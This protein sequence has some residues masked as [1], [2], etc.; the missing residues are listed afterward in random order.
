MVTKSAR[1]RHPKSIEGRP[2]DPQIW[3][4][5]PILL[6]CLSLLTSPAFAQSSS[7]SSSQSGPTALYNIATIPALINLPALNSSRPAIELSFPPTPNLFLT[8][9]LCSLTSNSSFLP[10]ILISTST[11]PAW[12]L[13]SRSTS[14]LGSGG[15]QEGGYNRRSRS[16]GL[17]SL[18]WDKGFGNWTVEGLGQGESVKVLLALN[19][20]TDG[21]S[22]I[23][24]G[25][26]NIAVQLGI[27]SLSKYS[28]R[29]P[30]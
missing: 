21:A 10:T 20:D 22:R 1:D 5:I 14:D 8:F 3:S 24:S 6:L 27:S 18:T 2:P 29:G 9:N 15:T 30:L 23:V 28:S 7:T 26:G 11:S 17:W 25:T 13:G 4:I 16:G 12:S 19:I